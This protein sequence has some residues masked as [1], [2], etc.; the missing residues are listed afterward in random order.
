MKMELTWTTL[1]VRKMWAQSWWGRIQDQ[2][3]CLA[4]SVALVVWCWPE[5]EVYEDDDNDD[6]D[7][8]HTDTMMIIK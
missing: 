8:G 3:F 7:D 2:T 1:Q 4:P 5:D 6:D